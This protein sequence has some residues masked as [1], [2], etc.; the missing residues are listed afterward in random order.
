V[1]VQNSMINLYDKCEEIN[2]VCRV[3]ERMGSN[4]T[5][6]SWS[7]MLAAHIRIRLW[8]ESTSLQR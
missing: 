6:A 7:A 1:F 2:V 5:V 4:M 8:F 3:F